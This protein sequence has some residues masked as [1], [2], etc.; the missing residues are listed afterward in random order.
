MILSF[1]CD[2]IMAQANDN[3]GEAMRIDRVKLVA[4]MARQD[5]SVKRLAELSGISRVTVSAV[6]KGK[7]CSEET[8]A[9]LVKALN[10]ET[11][12]IEEA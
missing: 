2:M 7:T 4:E 10:V 8:A 9:R 6:R 11:A 1:A 3:E 12:E 5:M